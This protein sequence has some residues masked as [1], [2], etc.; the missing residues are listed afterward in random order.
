VSKDVSVAERPQAQEKILKP[1]TAISAINKEDGLAATKI[2][3]ETLRRHSDA[4]ELW[5]GSRYE[6]V[7]DA[8]EEG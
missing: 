8:G 5:V 2:A 4:A 7:R 1:T 3:G 6:R